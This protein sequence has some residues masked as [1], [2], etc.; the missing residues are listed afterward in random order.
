MKEVNCQKYTAQVSCEAGDEGCVFFNNH[1][2][3][4]K[5]EPLLTH[6]NDSPFKIPDRISMSCMK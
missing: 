6:Y 2:N 5:T 1:M 4:T 3:D